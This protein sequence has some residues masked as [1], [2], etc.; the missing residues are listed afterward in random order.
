MTS[1]RTFIHIAPLLPMTGIAWLAAC[2]DKAKPVPGTDTSSSMSSPST[3][4]PSPA[5]MVQTPAPAMASSTGPMVDEKD[6]IAVSLGYVADATR[7]D[8]GKYKNYMAGQACANCALY[9]G[10]AG[11]ES[12]N[13][14]LFAGKQVASKGWCS[15]WV[16]KT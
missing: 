13:C 12:G 14:P 2:S 5:P 10:A 7:A 4:A 8:S 1:R 11:S 15:S 6:P 3:T 9:A 16:K